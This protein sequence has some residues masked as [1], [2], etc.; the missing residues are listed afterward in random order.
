MIFLGGYTS[1]YA[2]K[3]T[4]SEIKAG[5]I[6]NFTKFIKWPN[7]AN[8]QNFIFGIYGDNI[9]KSDFQK[10]L[11]SRYN[12]QNNWILTEYNKIENV[13]YCHVLFINTN[14]QEEL[15]KILKAVANQPVLTI[16]NNIPFFC[17]KGGLI[18]FIDEPNGKKFE[19]NYIAAKSKGFI[20]D[21][22]LLGVAKITGT[23]GL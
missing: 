21:S 14:N 18:N 17:Q 11:E 9:F 4:E 1:V 6:I 5:Y 13:E 20:I 12:A 16:G 7:S 2:Q 22:R 8:N 10:L 19:I 3:Y 23:T 15:E